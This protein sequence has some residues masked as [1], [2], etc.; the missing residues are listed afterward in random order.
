MGARIRTNIHGS[1]S[2]VCDFTGHEKAVAKKTWSGKKK[3]SEEEGRMALGR[4]KVTIY[5]LATC[6]WGPLEF[7]FFTF[8]TCCKNSLTFFIS[9]CISRRRSR[10][11]ILNS[12]AS[13]KRGDALS[14]Y[15]SRKLSLD[16]N[17]NSLR[18]RKHL[19]TV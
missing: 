17:V 1:T 10:E 13:P 14:F 18:S 7:F 11:C 15:A 2:W 16:I 19:R 5:D 8:A 12:F 4:N 6:E 3:T 9:N